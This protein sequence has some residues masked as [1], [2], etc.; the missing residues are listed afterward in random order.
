[1]KTAAPALQ[2]ILIV[3][4]AMLAVVLGFDRLLPGAWL[5]E[6]ELVIA[7]PPAAVY[8]EILTLKRWRDWSVAHSVPSGAKMEY[9]G[10]EAGTGAT[11]RWNSDDGRGVMKIM[12]T[13]RDRQMEYELLFD[14]GVRTMTGKIRLIP[15][16]KN[17]RVSWQVGSRSGTGPMGR[18]AAFLDKVHMTRDVEASLA[19]LKAQLESP[20]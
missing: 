8:R 17:T 14:G 2:R 20:R 7:V 4:L 6:R 3:V 13:L 16:D 12:D 5:V 9:S 19:N 1:M 11:L 10:P 18:Y 15:E